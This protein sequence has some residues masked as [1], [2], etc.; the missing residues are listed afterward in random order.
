M[1]FGPLAC[2]HLGDL[3]A[4]VIKLE[5]PE[6]DLTRAIGPRKSKD[7][8]AYF[9]N[10]NR[11][12]RS[13]V[14]DLKTQEGQVIL[15]KL[16]EH[17]D[18]LVH[19]TRSAGA[20]R[21]GLS[22]DSLSKLNPRLVFCHLT[23]YGDAGEYGGRPAY[24]D[25][26]QAESGLA[27]LQRVVG[28]APRFMPAIIADKVSGLHAAVGIM[29]ALM[30]RVRTGRGQDLSISMFETM[31][32]FNLVEH[33]WGHVFEPPTGS[34][35]YPPVSTGTRRPYPTR[36]GFLAVLPYTDAHWHAF[37]RAADAPQMM[38]DPRFSSF[39][40]RQR[41]VPA[42]WPEVE[43]QLA[44]KTN[45]QWQEL[46]GRDGVPFAIVKSLEDLRDDPHLASVGFWQAH[47]HPTEGDLRLTRSPFEFKGVDLSV[48][49]LPP[50]LG[51]HTREVLAECGCG[52]D[53]I[54]ALT[55]A[56]RQV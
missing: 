28:G 8:G 15:H 53:Q 30:Q 31:A 36:D 19:S 44:K 37:F 25:I 54:D 11:S 41:N 12:K 5:P 23:G 24:D 43:R 18:V 2:Q 7:M 48:R 46:L 3:G 6:G 52:P 56:V 38:Q 42:V 40:A 14:A 9:M 34:M 47:Q 49:K 51:E 13:V 20:A 39:E 26:I 32:A 35:G 50:R 1:I 10:C 29:A 45:A 55:G 21:I 33:Q 4:D 22:F 17:C 27:D 16:V